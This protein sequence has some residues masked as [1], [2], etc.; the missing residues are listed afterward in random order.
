MAAST[1]TG[2]G[3][4]FAW[5]ASSRQLYNSIHRSAALRELEVR[6]LALLNHP[7]ASGWI[8][9]LELAAELLPSA[10]DVQTAAVAGRLAQRRAMGTSPHLMH[11]HRDVL[12]LH[13]PWLGFRLLARPPVSQRPPA[14]ARGP[15]QDRRG[16]GLPAEGY[17]ARPIG[18]GVTVRQ[19]GR[20]GVP[21][22]KSR[23]QG[24]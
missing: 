17:A 5:L 21:A 6:T 10:R 23:S 4:V 9:L 19:A 15:G 16:P 24:P 3:L 1:K 18:L 20:Q 14:L 2:L 13:Y 12:V 22:A 7:R 8:S 11:H